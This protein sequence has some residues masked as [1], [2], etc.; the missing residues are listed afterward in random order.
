M[1]LETIAG[2]GWS[3]VLI[4]MLVFIIK[5]TYN[6]IKSEKER[7]RFL[8]EMKQGDSIYFP[9]ASGSIPGEIFEVNGDEVKVMVT[10]SKSRIYPKN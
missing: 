8:P 3:L 5:V 6:T 4:S 2:I 9:V 7:K 1:N 10:V